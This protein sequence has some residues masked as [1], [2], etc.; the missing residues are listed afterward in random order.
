MSLS[1]LLFAPIAAAVLTGV[2]AAFI[3][4]TDK[5]VNNYGTCMVNI[6]H[7]KKTL[8]VKGGSPLLFTLSEQKIF[9]PSACGGKGSCGACKVIIESDVG[10]VLPTEVPYL[11][12]EELKQ[13]T[14]L[15][16]Q[17]KVKK[18]IDI[19]I[20]E[21]IFNVKKLHSQVTSMKTLTYDIKE[22]R[23]ALPDEISFK[24]GQYLQLETPKYKH[25]KK[26]R[27]TTMR[28][29]SLSSSANKTKEAEMIIRL[30]PE[31]VVTTY[32]HQYMKEG[33]AVNLIGPFGDFYVRDTDATMVC[34]AGGS[35]MAPFKSIFNTM[36]ENGT[37][38]NR[39]IWYFFG[40]RALRD[41]YYQQWL[42]DL[43]KQYP[44]F[45]FIPA[46]SDP[47]PEDK[48]TGPTGLIT[49]VLDGYL[50][51]EISA[52][53]P[54]EGYLCGSPGMLDACMAVMGKNAMTADK[55]YFDKF[56]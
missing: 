25:E 3:D 10:P 28:A 55:I 1:L 39:E 45:H 16:C 17:V 41:L 8:A 27:D 56:A 33:D 46:L 37:F 23:F 11:S 9:V 47:L 19:F 54:R 7:D 42:T 31:G 15:S 14:R 2:L 51:K 29:Y 22:V 5:V 21:E 20:P 26:T 6:N 50:K 36:I 48:W 40:A 53:K 24:P 43:E 44:N 49:E 38:A 30:V 34:V 52:S 18:N 35:G 12:D 4:V 13:K 32:V